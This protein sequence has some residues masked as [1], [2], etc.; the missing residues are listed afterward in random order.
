VNLKG[1]RGDVDQDWRSFAG[2]QREGDCDLLDGGGGEG[3]VRLGLRNSLDELGEISLVVS[4]LLLL[5][6]DLCRAKTLNGSAIG[7]GRARK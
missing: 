5:V 3:V 7:L 1:E 4:E 6:V 2:L